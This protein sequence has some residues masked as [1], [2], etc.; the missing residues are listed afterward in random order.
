MRPESK[1]QF[2]RAATALGLAPEA[3][4]LAWRRMSDI[5][6]SPDDPT[7]VYLAV[8]GLLE[9]AAATVPAAIDALPARIEEAAKRAVGP[10]AKAATARVEA[11]HA[12]LAEQTGEAVAVAATA[13]FERAD[14]RRDFGIGLHLIG[15]FVAVAVGCGILGWSVGRSNVAGIATEWAALASRTD[16]SAWFGL[17][18]S[19]GDLNLTL[20]T[21][22]GPGAAAVVTVNGGRACN[23]PLWLDGSAAPAAGVGRGIYTGLVDWLAGWGPLWLLG[24]GV[25]AG[26]FGRKILLA[27]A[28]TGPVAWL[29]K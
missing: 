19:N 29:V 28:S 5:G 14:R 17:V 9:Q 3:R 13:H 20:R 2:E 1:L 24:G 12:A 21:Y 10:V 26:L 27:F 25:L 16:S 6:L 23:V 11:A 4:D 7:V 22:C 18:R 8:G 15:L